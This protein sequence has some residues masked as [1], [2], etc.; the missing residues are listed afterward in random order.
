MGCRSTAKR[1]LSL[2]RFYTIYRPQG[3]RSTAGLFHLLLYTMTRS[4]SRRCVRNSGALISSSSVPQHTCVTAVFARIVG[5]DLF[6][7]SM[8]TL[9]D[10]LLATRQVS[11]RECFGGEVT[12]HVD[13]TMACGGSL[14][15]VFLEANPVFVSFLL[16][17]LVSDSFIALFYLIVCLLEFTAYCP[18]PDDNASTK[19]AGV[20]R[21]ISWHTTRLTKSLGSPKADMEAP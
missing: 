7:L 20:S 2:F 16:Q 4:Q 15:P 9:L 3:K 11:A 10:R 12:T 17:L 6:C 19:V 13:S 18:D 5:D 1:Y 21:F 14:A 8:R